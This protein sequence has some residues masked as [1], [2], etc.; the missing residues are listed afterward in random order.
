MFRA[1]SD[2]RRP[3]SGRIGDGRR[4]CRRDPSED[5]FGRTF[6]PIMP[7]VGAAVLCTKVRSVSRPDVRE[8]GPMLR[9]NLAID[10]RKRVL[11][12]SDSRRETATRG[13]FGDSLRTVSF[14]SGRRTGQL[15]HLLPLISRTAP[16]GTARSVVRSLTSYR[17]GTNQKNELCILSVIIL[18]PSFS[19]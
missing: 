2:G 8:T 14:R 18:R 7:S 1:G 19:A 17:S 6:G 12:Q 4:F 15:R 16:A 5:G 13:C 11:R 3:D 10:P 9:R